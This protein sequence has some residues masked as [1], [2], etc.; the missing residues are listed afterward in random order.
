MTQFVFAFFEI[1]DR[2]RYNRY[3]EAA[4][5]IFVRE[6]VTI[7]AADDAPVPV[8][9]GMKADKAVLMEFRDADHMRAFFAL[10]DYIEI[11]K[12]RD[13]ATTMNAIQFQRFAGMETL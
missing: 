11:S 6:D 8:T 7:H 2:A 12:D 5:P 1:H 9:P 3:M 13:A 10:P 4:V